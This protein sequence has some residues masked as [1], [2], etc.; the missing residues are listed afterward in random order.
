MPNPVAPYLDVELGWARRRERSYAGLTTA[1]PLAHKPLFIKA[2]AAHD[3]LSHEFS[4]QDI[5]VARVA[6]LRL[7]IER[8]LSEARRLRE[9][10]TSVRARANQLRKEL[11]QVRKELG[12][13]TRKR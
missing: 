9:M 13:R 4:M 2:L 5:R 1:D 12:A 11:A 8:R 7:Q 6:K 3:L 10:A